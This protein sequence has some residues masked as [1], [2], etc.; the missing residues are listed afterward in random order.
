MLNSFRKKIF[1]ILFFIALSVTLSYAQI[2]R[3]V[4]KDTAK[5][6][7]R[8]TVK[9]VLKDSTQTDTAKTKKG[10]DID[11][12]VFSTAVDSMTMN[13]KS[14][15]MQLY[16]K[17]EIKYKTT[18]LKGAKIF[19][20][21]ETN[22]LEAYGIP[23]STGKQLK[24]TP[25]LTDGG[26]VYDGQRMRYNFKTQQGFISAA[27][28]KVKD[29]RYEGEKVK[30][31]DK[32]T[33]FI[34]DGIFTTCSE[35]E[36]HTYFSA[37]EMK[38]MTND[39][40]IAKWVFMHICGIPI[41]IPLPMAVIPNQTGRRSG[42]IIPGYGDDVNRGLYL[43]H[44][45]YF[46]ALSDYF[47]LAMTTDLYSR[48]GYG[49][50]G[51]FRYNKRYNFSGE[52][53]AGYSN[54]RTD[55]V[56]NREW[57]LSL[58]HNQN[59]TPT[60]T[61]VA[62]LQFQSASYNTYNT[63]DYN[64]LMRQQVFSRATYSKTFEDFGA[65]LS[66][67]YQRTQNIKDGTY[68]ET[69]PSF[70]FSKT[71]FYP[72]KSKSKSGVIDQK[73][74]D[75]IGVNY[76]ANFDNQR[77]KDTSSTK[78]NA[79]IKHALTI[80]ASP[81]IGYFTITP[82]F[83]YTEKWYPKHIEMEGVP[84]GVDSTGKEK[85]TTVTREINKFS[86]V[87]SFSLGVSASTRI[88]GIMPAGFLGIE[89]FR[90][91][92]TP[93]ISYNYTPD[94]SSESWGYYG[95]YKNNDGKLV[96]YDKFGNEIYGGSG[97]G[98]SQYLSFGIGNVFELKTIKDPTDTTSQSKKIQ[99]LNF[100]I[101]SGYNFAADSLKLAALN[102]SFRTQIGE[103]LDFSGTA[104]YTFYDANSE[105]TRINKYLASAGK[106]LFRLTNFYF[107]VSTN[108]SAE[109][110][111]SNEEKKSKNEEMLNDGNMT[112]PNINNSDVMNINTDNSPDYSIPWNLAL[113]LNYNSD[114]SNP[115]KPSTASSSMSANFSMNL[116][117]KWK[118]SFYGNYDFQS[119]LISA[120]QITVNRDL[121][122]W[123]MNLTWRPLGSYKGF[124]F[125]IRMKA[126][127]FQD[128]KVEKTDGQFSGLR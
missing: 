72:F 60:S 18:D 119:K 41:P 122:C 12:V 24:D 97:S 11:A 34:E 124:Y 37:S 6:L 86:F 42:I 29:T 14:R 84:A 58:N 10:N 66:L 83:N 61:L 113:S 59:I 28:N 98:E 47:D 109:K 32:E 17:G 79:G 78:I 75:L 71:T 13:V 3:P 2:T 117:K 23:D 115:N 121:H 69:L 127:E 25:V 19:V 50:K 110:F 90:H 74:Y 64:T 100:S 106:G 52:L 77:I 56:N 92:V 99:L 26:Q 125:V 54:T 114:H 31:V 46:L 51:R 123:E 9:T 102:T 38:V 81:K 39:K 108:L 21:Y 7:S 45:G 104:N 116:T 35:K 16:G 91:T 20:D 63:Y 36:P 87:R 22:E 105:G 62:Q 4:V 68:T 5:L 70:N 53:N 88:Y 30:K 93:T 43:S 55:D 1:P 73:W 120:P 40:I 112:K 48:G 76:S 89:A 101:G 44:L 80:N 33:F 96:K 82:S 65:S 85:Y 8:D 95:T 49:L 126:P 94:F 118:L 67:S 111:R 128:I 107:S 103:L 15:K 57:N 27:S